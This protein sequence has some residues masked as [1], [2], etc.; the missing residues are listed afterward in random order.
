MALSPTSAWTLT[1]TSTA[2]TDLTLTTGT[3][4]PKS[5]YTFN[6]A[7]FNTNPT[8]TEVFLK[9]YTIPAGKTELSFYLELI[10]N[11]APAA[12]EVTYIVTINGVQYPLVSP[13]TAN[14]SDQ[15]VFHVPAGTTQVQTN[16]TVIT[17]NVG[18]TVNNIRV[19]EGLYYYDSVINANGACVSSCPEVV[20]QTTGVAI[21]SNPPV[22]IYCP[23][24]TNKY[25]IDGVC[26]CKPYYFLDISTDTC[27]PCTDPLCTTCTTA[28]VCTVC[29]GNATLTVATPNPCAC[30]NG[31]YRNG[32]I[33]VACPIG[34]ALC[35]G[36][37]DCSQ[38]RDSANATGFV[39]RL[40]ETFAC[41]CVNGFYD[42][43]TTAVC[44]PCNP[45]CATCS[46]AANNCT[47]C[48]AALNFVQSQFSC[49]CQTG[50]YLL[51]N[52]CSLCNP[53]CRTCDV[54]SIYCTSCPDLRVLSGTT[55]PLYKTCKCNQT[56]GLIELD[57]VCVDALCLDIDPFCAQCEI[58][59]TGLR[60]RY[61]TRCRD[62]RVVVGGQCVCQP[63]FF[64]AADG[65][66][67]PCGAGCQSC[68]NTT[69]CLTC[70]TS[71]I[72]NGD[73]TCSCRPGSTLVTFTNTMYCQPC[74]YNCAGCFGLPNNCTS[75]KFGFSLSAGGVC[76]CPQG[77]Y[78][79]A[80]GT[81]CISCPANC[82]DCNASG[83]INCITGYVIDSVLNQCTL[84]C[85][86]GQFNAGTA[87]R[88]CPAGCAS[89][90]TEIICSSC[91][92]NYFMYAGLCRTSCPDGS[93]STNGQCVRCPLQ[94][95][96]C[97]NAQTCSSCSSNFVLLAGRCV[98]DCPTN[99][100]Y[101]DGSCRACDSSC[102][103]C[104]GYAT[105]CLT[106]P[107]G[108]IFYNGACYAACPV[109]T[110]NGVC[111]NVCP[112]GTYLSGT[113]CLPC[114]SSCRTCFGTANN[115][116][117]CTS[118]LSSGGVCIDSCPTGTFASSGFCTACDASC[119]TCQNSP[120]NCN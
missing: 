89:C 55:N 10:N 27:T 67:K 81:Q 35:T 11:V 57:Y 98:G 29:A 111:T 78:A 42:V 59:A 92:P 4:I 14:P 39:T 38:C 17:K 86:V 15:I 76:V 40:N 87:C 46:G 68:T 64:Q 2:V 119:R 114:G 1:G 23:N 80:D 62:N 21:D 43:N 28:A 60:I 115:C 69:V 77:T 53:I 109:A 37:N 8:T 72:S 103:T 118:G 91:L 63:G 79:S 3:A 95:K 61:C 108:S 74:D 26:A 16:V 56:A 49:V 83:C 50:Y 93:F 99:T 13:T 100:F 97:T 112:G 12:G 107:T 110:V 19:L 102:A 51:N 84:S 24:D 88:A 30:N 9:N 120:F 5:L 32:S 31:F 94:C 101:A 85:A 70:A 58:D 54:S 66:C 52:Q 71:S 82:R 106:C 47:S 105:N 6:I 33:C 36:P 41:R 34:C 113:S 7:T 48:N 44:S 96:T 73:G 18:G 65:T 90:F 75:C 117:S 25:Y 45:L 116:T 20:N 104:T 22:C